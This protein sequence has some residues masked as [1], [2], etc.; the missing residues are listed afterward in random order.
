MHEYLSYYSP[1]LGQ[2]INLGADYG[3]PIQENGLRDYAFGY[4]T[5]SNRIISYNNDKIVKKQFVVRWIGDIYGYLRSE[6]HDA[7]MSDVT[8]GVKGRLY[9]ASQHYVECNIIEYE[10]SNNFGV[11]GNS[12]AKYSVV[13]DDY[14]WKKD[15]FL[16]TD[17][18]ARYLPGMG[19]SI[20]GVDMKVKIKRT[21]GNAGA[22]SN[23]LAVWNNEIFDESYTTRYG[24]S[25]SNT[26][27]AIVIDTAKKTI[28]DDAGN[29]LFS[30]R[31]KAD[32]GSFWA[33]SRYMTMLTLTPTS[34]TTVDM[35]IKIKRATPNLINFGGH[36]KLTEHDT[37]GP[38]QFDPAD[39]VDI[40]ES[41]Y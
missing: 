41:V 26:C 15:A 4:V 30:N 6:F 11:K 38:H 13:T 23:V 3:C 7:I 35:D 40:W 34:G 9:D 2:M 19:A 39:H 12:D 36:V 22:I 29:N 24:L 14:A 5:N 27:K 16:T 10:S 20:L 33:P 25:G 1:T 28:I 18:A 17:K 37:F 21:D 32:L 8:A 31:Y